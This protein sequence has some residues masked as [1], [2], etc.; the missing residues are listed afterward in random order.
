[1]LWGK[2]FW[3]ELEVKRSARLSG[4][5]SG[6]KEAVKKFF[7]STSSYEQS[8][9]EF[10]K[11]LQ[12]ILIKSDV[13]VKTVFELSNKIKKRALE[14]KPP[15]GVSRRDW[16]I[17][18]V[19][20]ELV[21]LLGGEEEISFLPKKKP[22]I[23]MLV[24]IQGS[25]KTTT[26]AKL[27]WYYKSRKFKVGLVAADTFRAGAYEQLK[28]LSEKVQAMFWGN[29]NEKD[30]TKLSLEGVKELTANGA[31]III[32]DTAGRHGYGEEQSLIDEMKKIAEA[33]KPDEVIFVLDASI[34]QKAADIAKK[35]HEA[36][37]IGS[38]I[39]TKLD[40][41]AKGGGAISAV[42]AT[43]A[44]IKFIGTGEKIDEIEPFRPK[45]FV[46]RIL[47]MG[48]IEALI[49]RIY[50]ISN[51]KELE[52]LTEDIMS[53]NLNMRV[54]YKQ[55]QQIRNMGPLEKIL[56]MIPGLSMALPEDSD[57]LKISEEKM[58]RWLSII[59]SMTF[60]ELQKPELVEKEKSRQKRIALG[61]GTTIDDVKE[62][63]AYYENT[64]RMLKQLKRNK[65]LLK[66]LSKS[67]ENII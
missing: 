22:Y 18:I 23:I 20:E 21:H 35:F 65:A 58:D 45:N 6:L 11:D 19:Y 36:T 33:V 28:Q 30:A 32:I 12:R 14:E 3:L 39:V 26:A 8:I 53:G 42:A 2:E 17:K 4:V 44:K 16:F 57:K 1:M 54:I 27:A 50:A 55:I 31:E 46:S 48:D 25:G 62:L 56:K 37:P 67:G 13:N 47:G 59:D 51:E 60:E 38:I 63:L 15:T 24:G 34:G 43:G 41:T 52:K 5:F 29:P 66:R 7:T 61:S 9:E 49:D 64:K 10:V 40:G